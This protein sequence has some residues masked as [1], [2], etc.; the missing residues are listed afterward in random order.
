MREKLKTAAWWIG[1][2]AWWTIL[3]VYGTVTK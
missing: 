3:F 2:A 1:A